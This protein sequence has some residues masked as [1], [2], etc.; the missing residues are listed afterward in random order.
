MAENKRKKNKPKKVG[1]ETQ[2]TQEKKIDEK[3]TED[4]IL[5]TPHQG[6][7]VSC[8]F[9][10]DRFKDKTFAVYGLHL[11]AIKDF[12]PTEFPTVEASDRIADHVFLLEDGSYAIVDYESDFK[13]EK[14]LE[15]LEY[16]TRLYRRYFDPNKPI[17]IRF[18]VIYTC[19]VK[20]AHSSIDAGA[21]R[22]DVEEAFMTHID[23]DA[24]FERLKSKF[25]NGENFTDEDIM[26]LIILPI[27]QTKNEDIVGMID[28]V[29]EFAEEMKSKNTV[30][31]T[32][33][34]VFVL[35]AMSTALK[36]YVTKKHKEKIK[37]VIAMTSLLQDIA[38]EKE[39]YGKDML[40][41][42][43]AQ[44][45][46]DL[47]DR[48]IGRGLSL[49]EACEQIGIEPATYEMSQIVMRDKSALLA[50]K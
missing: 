32:D 12:L 21:L 34:C 29:I 41:Y 26:K 2:K 37:E 8:K 6:K 13:P 3:K 43:K 5:A 33:I 28:N 39:Q 31:Y 35:A 14:K 50:T 10:A 11:P 24:E 42:G 17:K 30:A 18:I 22:L 45:Y 19:K 23:G 44:T 49:D 40:D 16:A 1:E 15:Y 27:T 38:Y 4:K 46:V 48:K 7:D 25:R 9:L 36:N 47:V 20:S